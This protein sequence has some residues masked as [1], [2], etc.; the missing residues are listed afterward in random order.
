[1]AD[2]Q[3]LCAAFADVCGATLSPE[4]A[5]GLLQLAREYRL[6]GRGL[7]SRWETF[8]TSAQHSGTADGSVPVAALGPFTA[9]L[10]QQGLSRRAAPSAGRKAVA[11]AQAPA[12]APAPAAAQTALPAK[13]CPA[14]P[15]AAT[16]GLTP[17]L[18]APKQPAGTAFA[19]RGAKLQAEAVLNGHLP[20]GGVRPPSAPALRIVLRSEDPGAQAGARFMHERTEARV[21][22]LESRLAEFGGAATTALGLPPATQPLH[23]ASSDPVTVAGR[24]VSEADASAGRLSATSVLL[25]GSH[26]HSAGARVRLELQ[27][28]PHY[29]L[30]P[31]QCLL[32]R[33]ANPS[34][35][36][37][38]A[39]ALV[40]GVALPQPA[41]AALPHDLTI[42]AAA[43]PFT[44]A[45]DMQYEP[46]Q[47]LLAYCATTQPA[48]LVLCGPFVDVEHPLCAAGSMGTTFDELFT[49][50]LLGPLSDFAAANPG[51]AV[52]LQPAGGREAHHVPV[53]PT[54]P[55][56]LDGL[57]Q[58]NLVCAANPDMVE[59]RA[60]DGA[61]AL[62]LGVCATDVI[63]ALSSTEV[64]T[65]SA[66]TVAPLADDGFEPDRL[67]RLCGHV[68][69]Q[70]C[71]F[72]VFPAPP[73]A[74]LDATH[75]ATGLA[76]TRAPHVLLLPSDVAPFARA[77]A[78]RVRGTQAPGGGEA[79][80][81]DGDDATATSTWFASQARQAAQH[82]TVCV[83]PGRLARGNLGGTFA[84]LTVQKG[85]PSSSGVR[86]DI[87]RV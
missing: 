59:L 61:A 12:P 75:A 65:L 13:V 60:A 53:L 83:N 5:S 76:M 69:G 22:W 70:G 50:K 35:F 41:S 42:V 4:A 25:E 57:V 68:L 36:C 81:V 49:A 3:G 11:P 30:F 40:T 62:Q 23:V 52:V 29:S 24:V 45:G 55:L 38:V 32:V 74:C 63:K 73:G 31:G 85:V 17:P 20:Q 78:T 16:A 28:L 86:V 58:A 54:P 21:D 64:C 79:M 44:C 43:G 6:D 80:H 19:A 8:C 18:Y 27:R 39:D 82:A 2:E 72:P 9:W 46:L 66:P 1:M 15:A 84:V 48:L 71:F 14:S 10:E 37:L 77:V 33:G 87:V 47:E 26:Q 7:A 34:G 67:A 56:K 51:V